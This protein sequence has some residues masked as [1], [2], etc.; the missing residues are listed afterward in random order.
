[1]PR[2][3]ISLQAGQAGNQSMFLFLFTFSFDWVMLDALLVM[4]VMGMYQTRGNLAI[5]LPRRTVAG[6][7][8]HVP[9]FQ[10]QP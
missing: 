10:C 1:M 5:A 9:G 6:I 3:I 7:V 2:E 4:L 8:T